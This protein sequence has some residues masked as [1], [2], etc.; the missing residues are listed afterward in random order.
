M[1]LGSKFD[2][3]QTSKA[4]V[5][6]GDLVAP[7]SAIPRDYLGDTPLLCAMGFSV[8]QH[9]CDTPSSFSEHVPLGE[10]AK[11]RCDNPP[12]LL[13]RGISAMLARYPLKTRQ[14][15]AMPPSAILS[16]EGIARYGGLS[17]WAAKFQ[18]PAVH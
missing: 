13:K 11:W 15:V 16:R 4:S 1:G 7:Y 5:Y 17:H 3:H 10:H 2:P 12:S 6:F 9:G 18:S 8:S 14:M